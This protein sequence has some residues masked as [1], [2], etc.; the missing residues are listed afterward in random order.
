[1]PLWPRR[2][3]ELIINSTFPEMNGIQKMVFTLIHPQSGNLAF[4]LFS[5]NDNSYFDHIQR[6]NYYSIILL[7]SGDVQIKVD[8]SEYE[9]FSPSGLFFSPYQPFMII[10]KNSLE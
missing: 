7:R 4:K 9:V 8:F 5:F 6:H 1:M 3:K 2:H 10:A